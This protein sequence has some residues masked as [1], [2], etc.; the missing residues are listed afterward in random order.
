MSEVQGGGQE[1]GFKAWLRKFWSGW[2]IGAVD[3]S[4]ADTTGKVV[5]RKEGNQFFIG[6]QPISD[7]EAARIIGETHQAIEEDNGT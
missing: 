1:G 7:D 2:P 5:L 6:D 4:R 3:S